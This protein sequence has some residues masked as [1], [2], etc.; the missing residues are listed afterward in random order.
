MAN[1][2]V[3]NVGDVLLTYGLDMACHKCVVKTKVVSKDE[4]GIVTYSDGCHIL[5]SWENME[6][7]NDY[8]LYS[9]EKEKEMQ[10]FCDNAYNEW[11]AACKKQTERA[12]KHHIERN[13]RLKSLISAKGGVVNL[14]GKDD[15]YRWKPY[16]IVSINEKLDVLGVAE[17]NGTMSLNIDDLCVPTQQRIEK[18]IEAA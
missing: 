17:D 1:L 5:N 12:H 9:A 3:F 2:S 16:T 11:V 10:D 18:E 8:F 6:H 13:E 15:F 7:Y 4:R 14:S